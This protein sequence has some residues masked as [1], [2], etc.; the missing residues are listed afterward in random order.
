MVKLV[1]LLKRKEG[2]SREAFAKWWITDHAPIAKQLPGLRGYRINLTMPSE[3]EPMFDGTAELWF[4]S[5]EAMEAAF[6]S[7]IGVRAGEDADAH[8][9]LRVHLYTEENI[10]V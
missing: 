7:P 8:T 1:A 2:L 3:E 10:I 5:V 6:S 9:R 4:D